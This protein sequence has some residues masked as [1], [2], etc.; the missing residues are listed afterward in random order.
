MWPVPGRA[1]LH[2]ILAITVGGCLGYVAKGLAVK[3]GP[4]PRR[5]ILPVPAVKARSL[6][7]PPASPVSMAPAPSMAAP[8]PVPAIDSSTV[9]ATAM[10]AVIGIRRY[11]GGAVSGLGSGFF[12]S[13]EGYAVTNN[14]V[15]DG[16]SG[17][18]TLLYGDQ[19]LWGQVVATD[20]TRD[21]AVLRVRADE[22]LP[23]LALGTTERLR[24]GK[25][26]WA[27][28]FPMSEKLGFTLTKG[29]V[30]GLRDF[31]EPRGRFVQH[32]AA[33]NPGNSGGPLLNDEG[34]VVGVN[35]WKLR[36]A[37]RLGFAVP[38]EEIRAFVEGLQ[39]LP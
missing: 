32:D 26:V 29:I 11:E 12:V 30:S 38:A 24:P 17:V 21:L 27:I 7:A 25:A 36:G 18:E 6:A 1:F 35:T 22:P 9:M 37:D 3:G 13:P 2:A 14:H 5:E 20:A 8:F 39:I 16:L 19:K 34:L 23:F 10:R 4:A 31:D 33:I 15:I 28:G